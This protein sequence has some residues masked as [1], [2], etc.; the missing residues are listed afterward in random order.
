MSAYPPDA[1]ARGYAPL[2]RRES[3]HVQAVRVRGVRAGWE[4]L[5]AL[6][7]APAVTLGLLVMLGL[8]LMVLG[9]L[10]FAAINGAVT[11]LDWL[12]RLLVARGL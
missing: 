6:L 5:Y 9:S 4:R 8:Y 11:G 12:A 10:A 3:H 1:L 7:L 2:I